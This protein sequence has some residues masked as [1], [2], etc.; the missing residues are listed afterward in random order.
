MQRCN[1]GFAFR[2]GILRL[3]MK[4]APARSS[5]GQFIWAIF[6]LLVALWIIA[7]AA[8][9]G[10][11]VITYMLVISLAVLAIRSAGKRRRRTPVE[12]AAMNEERAA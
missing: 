6:I 8:H 11:G 10:G 4:K 5:S 7:F 12:E 2:R 3:F 9:L 1:N